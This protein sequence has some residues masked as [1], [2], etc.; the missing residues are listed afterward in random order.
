[1]SYDYPDD[2]V[3][4]PRDTRLRARVVDA[5]WKFVIWCALDCPIGLVNRW[6]LSRLGRK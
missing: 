5:Y 6:G 3:P 4:P 1:M 2:Y